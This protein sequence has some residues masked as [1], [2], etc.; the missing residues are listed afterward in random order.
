MK[1]RYLNRLLL[2]ILLACVTS[3][4]FA[5]LAHTITAYIPLF[6]GIVFIII[7]LVLLGLIVKS[8]PKQWFNFTKQY[9]L[10][11]SSAIFIFI[12]CAYLD[13]DNVND[14]ANSIKAAFGEEGSSFR[15]R[16]DLTVQRTELQFVEFTEALDETLDT[17]ASDNP[18]PS[19][20]SLDTG[21]DKP[22]PAPTIP[23]IIDPNKPVK[24]QVRVDGGILVGADWDP[25]ILYN[26]PNA[27]NPTWD[28]LKVFL[29]QDT[30]DQQTYIFGSFV[31][32][33]FAEM[34]HNN[35]EAAGLQCA[36][37]TIEL[38]PSSYFPAAGHALNAF[39]TTDRGLVYIDCTGLLGTG[40][41]FNADKVVKVVEGQQYIPQA[42]FPTGGWY[43]DSM[44]KVLSIE[45]I[46]W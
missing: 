21:S 25:I 30:T 14:L 41:S 1:R 44:G 24:Q 45:I 12:S 33:D 37:V 46:Q 18:T 28:E 19:L 22:T 35:A 43:W 27:K 8:L 6:I 29:K 38:G 23:P 11:L 7:S 39:E 2:V 20:T 10:L 34:L 36:Y 42:V 9:F 17:P 4:M 16:I 5:A 15:E 31:C 13:I 40:N 3:L 32:A 26:Y